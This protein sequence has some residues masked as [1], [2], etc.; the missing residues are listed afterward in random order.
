MASLKGNQPSLF[1][2]VK[3]NF[4]PEVTDLQ[5][6]KGHGRIE[7]RHVSICK[8]LDSIRPW[9]GLT[10]LIQVKS[11]RQVFTHHVIE[12]TTETRYY[13]SSLSLTAQEF[14]ERIRG[15]WGV[16]NKVHYGARCYSR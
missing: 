2:E 3:T 15:Y 16:E 14:A 10:T 1:K 5:I 7:K 12:V 8:N 6:N 11:E 4:T 13:I 9:P